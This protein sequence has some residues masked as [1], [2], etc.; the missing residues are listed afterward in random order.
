MP[1]NF[2]EAQCS[3]FSKDKL[4]GICD[5]PPPANNPAYL[6]LQNRNNWISIVKNIQEKE[7]SF[8]AIDNCIEVL[9]PDGTLDSRCDGLLKVNKD[10]IFIELKNRVSSGWLSKGRSQLT[11]TINVF[12]R[13]HNPNDFDSIKAYVSNKQR[14]YSNTIHFGEIQRFRNDTSLILRVQQEIEI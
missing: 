10:L 7:F 3:S 1:I 6:D 11:N 4:I 12:R 5:D 9:K 8:H 13:T 2:F 14:P